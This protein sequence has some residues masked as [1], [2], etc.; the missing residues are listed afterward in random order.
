MKYSNSNFL[1]V[2]GL[3]NSALE[4]PRRYLQE[5][6]MYVCG[7]RPPTEKANDEEISGKMVN[8]LSTKDNP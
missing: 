5:H 2:L 4:L 8:A 7:R 6:C 1:N 3:K